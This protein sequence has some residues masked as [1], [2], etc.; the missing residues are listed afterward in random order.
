MLLCGVMQRCA[1]KGLALCETAI[2]QLV[3]CCPSSIV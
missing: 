3:L 1:K 2:T